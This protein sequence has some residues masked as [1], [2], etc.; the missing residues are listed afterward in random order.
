[1][2]SRRTRART[3]IALELL[4]SSSAQHWGY[5]LSRNSGVGPGTMYP[6]LAELLSAG[7]LTDGWE[8][9]EAVVGKRPPRRYYRVT[10]AGRRQLSQFVSGARVSRSSRQQATAKLRTT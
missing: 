7:I 10:E 1:M 3:A 6:Y 8:D 2:T 4:S 5:E 9:P